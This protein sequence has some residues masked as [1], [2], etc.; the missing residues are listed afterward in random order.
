MD[1][2]FKRDA[3]N[4]IPEEFIITGNQ[5]AAVSYDPE[6]GGIPVVTARGSGEMAKELIRLAL[7]HNIPIKY[8][9]DLVQVLS[10]LDAGERIPEDVF[11]VV[12]ELL[13]FVYWVN[14]EYFFE[15]ESF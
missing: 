7:E 13:A 15:S 14:K 11:L 5:A 3:D 8:D 2:Q 9:P 4:D 12:A 1:E 6:K 10:K